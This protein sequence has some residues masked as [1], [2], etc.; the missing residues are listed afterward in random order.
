MWLKVGS[1]VF[2]GDDGADKGQMG[3]ASVLS[4]GAEGAATGSFCCNVAA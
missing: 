2:H 3:E 1:S 4:I